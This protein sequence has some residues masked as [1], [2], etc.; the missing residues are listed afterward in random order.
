MTLAGLKIKIK[1]D[2]REEFLTKL[3]EAEYNVVC[4]EQEDALL[5]GL[6][7]GAQL[8]GAGV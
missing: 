3:E 4:L 6:R 1:C 7:I 2:I 8:T 5:L